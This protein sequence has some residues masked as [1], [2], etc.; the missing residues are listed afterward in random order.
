MVADARDVLGPLLD[1]V[2]VADDDNADDGEDLESE[3]E[4]PESA[5]DLVEEPLQQA[6]PGLTAAAGNRVVTCPVCSYLLCSTPG[7]CPLKS[8]TLPA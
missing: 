6:L 2:N 8:R 1:P 3:E 7:A 4:P 5:D